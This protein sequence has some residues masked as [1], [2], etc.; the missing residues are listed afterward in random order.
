MCD[1]NGYKDT[2]LIRRRCTARQYRVPLVKNGFAF[3]TDSSHVYMQQHPQP[4]SFSI[5]AVNGR[6][7]FGKQSRRMRGWLAVGLQLGGWA[8]YGVI[9]YYAHRPFNPFN[10]IVWKQALWAASTGLAVSSLLGWAYARLR[11]SQR[12]LL[13]QAGA[14]LAGSGGAGLGWYG[15]NQW[16]AD[17]IDPFVA[18]VAVL[19]TVLPGAGSLLSHPAAFPV[20]LLGWSAFYLGIAHGAERQAQQQRV[21]EADAEAQRARLRMLRY[22]LN[23]HFFFNALN[24]ISALADESPQRVKAA[25]RELSGFLRYSLLSDDE[26]AVPL[27]EELDAIE[28]YMAVEKM[29]FEDDLQVT[30]EVAAA[31][32]SCPV[33]AF[34]VLPLVENAIKHGQRTSPFPLEVVITGT[35]T[36]ADKLVIEVA[37][38]GHLRP[39]AAPAEACTGTGL[40]NV[41]GRLRAQYPE[42]HAFGLEEADGWVRARIAID[43]AAI[44]RAAAHAG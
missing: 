2:A 23:P 12:S 3:G 32:A 30:L 20:I 31:A 17:W 22:Q 15:V 5:H 26:Q 35:V 7:L 34:L 16:G 39:D 11:V 44:N 40:A 25:V 1:P 8:V 4:P 13:W 27:R 6:G 29:R 38:T 36:E 41:R 9:H 19:V 18:P 37:N 43:R 21:L 10:D 33:P 14:V 42:A 28:H 24:T